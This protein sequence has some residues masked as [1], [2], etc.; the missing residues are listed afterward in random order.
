VSLAKFRSIR[1]GRDVAEQ[2]K[3][4]GHKGESYNDVIIRLLPKK[5]RWKLDKEKAKFEG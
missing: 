4:I 5:Y 1:I 3:L 2:L